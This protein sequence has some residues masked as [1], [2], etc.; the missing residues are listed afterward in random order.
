MILFQQKSFKKTRQIA[1]LIPGWIDVA[2]TIPCLKPFHACKRKGGNILQ[3]KKTL[4]ALCAIVYY[5]IWDPIKNLS[6][7]W[8]TKLGL[9]FWVICRAHS[10]LA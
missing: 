2:S 8:E 4:S 6:W 7:G 10:Y 1:A 9:E 3:Q 5:Y